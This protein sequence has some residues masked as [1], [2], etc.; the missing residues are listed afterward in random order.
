M[1]SCPSIG[2]SITALAEVAGV[3]LGGLDDDELD[4]A[5]RLVVECDDQRVLIRIG[6]IVEQVRLSESTADQRVERER[7]ARQALIEAHDAEEA[8]TG[9]FLVPRRPDLPHPAQAGLRMDDGPL[10]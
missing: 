3:P 7:L 10:A 6:H 8:R 9:L 2:E 4:V 1:E 5:L